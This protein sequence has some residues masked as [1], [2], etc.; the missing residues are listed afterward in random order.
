MQKKEAA[1]LEKPMDGRGLIKLL[2]HAQA[3]GTASLPGLGVFPRTRPVPVA[4][5]S[6]VFLA[7]KHGC[8]GY[9]AY[10]THVL[11]STNT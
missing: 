8:K 11:C 10:C 9:S 1:A 2:V 7:D 6:P 3:A 5:A 4:G